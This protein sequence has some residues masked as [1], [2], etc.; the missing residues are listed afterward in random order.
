M[1]TTGNDKHPI[2]PAQA[3]ARRNNGKA[4]STG[5]RSAAGK[6]ASSRNAVRHGL[7]AK[8]DPVV[9]TGIFAEDPDAFAR[10]R[11]R[12]HEHYRTDSPLITELVDDLASVLWR[13]K[14][15]PGL[16]ALLLQEEDSIEDRRADRARERLE[17]I[18][19]T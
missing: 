19:L 10:L 8:A 7:W 14:R 2:T 16:E 18:L 4:H 11:A 15:I 9:D 17:E 13:I 3:E 5:P 12:L 1:S 6:Q